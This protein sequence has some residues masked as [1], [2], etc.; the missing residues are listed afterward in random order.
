MLQRK[1]LYWFWGGAEGISAFFL[2][3]GWEWQRH[4]KMEL[5]FRRIVVSA[6]P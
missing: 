5:I 4:K 2:A 3:C 1:V 6:L